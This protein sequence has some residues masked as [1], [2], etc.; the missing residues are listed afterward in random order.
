MDLLLFNLKVA[1]RC[2]KGKYVDKIA[3]MATIIL[4]SYGQTNIFSPL[5][6]GKHINFDLHEHMSNIPHELLDG[7]FVMQ[8]IAIFSRSNHVI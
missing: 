6:L 1:W 8:D 5:K 7:Y 4:S 2:P 3:W